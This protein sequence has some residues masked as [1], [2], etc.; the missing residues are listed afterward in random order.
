LKTEGLNQATYRACHE[1][2]KTLPETSVFRTKLESWLRSTLAIQCR[3]GLGQ[4]GIPVSTDI[5][6]SLFGTFKNCLQRQAQQGITQSILAI[7]ALT[8]SQCP[9]HLL[10]ALSSVANKEIKAWV[11]ENVPTSEV[12]KRRSF[13]KGECPNLVPRLKAAS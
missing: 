8:G 5:I 11:V 1:Q 13:L 3:L 7:P 10:E 9:F 4:L 12:A 6:E 2:L